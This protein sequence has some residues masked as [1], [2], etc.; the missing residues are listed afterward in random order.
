MFAV[1]LTK[2]L[3]SSVRQL[4]YYSARSILLDS[5]W[6]QNFM[7]MIILIVYCKRIMKAIRHSIACA[8]ARNTY[9]TH[10]Y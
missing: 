1:A 4:I 5:F 8:G 6:I 7:Y 10:A 2:V 3:R 9:V